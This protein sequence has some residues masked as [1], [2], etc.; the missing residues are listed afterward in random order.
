MDEYLREF[1]AQPDAKQKSQVQWQPKTFTEP[2]K[3][4]D[5]YPVGNDQPETHMLTVNWLLN[6]RP[7]TPLQDLTLDVLNHLLMGT[8][9]AKLRKSLMESGLGVAMTG[10]GVSD[11]LLQATFSVGLKGIQ[12]GKTGE[13][14]K[15]ILDTLESVAREGFAQ[16]EIAS[17]LNTIEFQMREFNTGS[18]PKGLSF[19]LGSMN[20]W[21]Y[22]NSPT[23]ALKFEE[24]LKQLKE[25]IA[26][27]GS[28]IFQDM[29]KTMLVDN[30]HRTTVELAPSKTLEQEILKD[31]ES[32]LAAIK[33][34]M[35]DEEL[36]DVVRKTIELKK[37]Q[38]RE[39]P[40][41]ARATIPQLELSDLKRETTEYPIVVTKNEG[42]SGV[43]VVRHEMG[44]TSGIAYCNLMVDLSRL[45]LDDV[46][47]LPLFTRVMKETGAGDMDS[48]ALS[49]KIG[50]HTG[51]IDVKLFTSPVYEEGVD[52]SNAGSG[53]YMVTKLQIQGKAT[54]EKID[55]LFDLFKV[56]LTDARFD[57][58]SKV[59][60]LLKE[61]KSR[62]ES[63]VQGSGH[64]IVNTRMKARHRVDGYVEEVTDGITH[65]SEVKKLLKTAEEDWPSLLTRLETIRSTILDEEY[66]RSGMVLDVTGDENVLS[67]I[68]PSL[69]KFLNA[70]PGKADGSSM[71]DAYSNPHPWAAE[72]KKKMAEILPIKDE[73]FVVPTQ[74]NY[75]GKSGLLYDVG[76]HIPG[77][78]AVV[79]RFLRTGYIW[80][81]VRVMGGAYGGYCM[82]SPYSGYLSFLS[83]RDPNLDKTID[84]YDA[85]ADALT[86]IADGLE[87]DPAALAKAIIGAIGDMDKALS[88]D[89]KGVKQ[90]Q[91]WLTNETAEYRQKYRDE[92]LSTK[93]SDFRD[94]AARLRNMKSASVAVVSSKAGFE[95]AAK[96]GKEMML[97]EI[98]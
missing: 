12:P 25:S 2:K 52:N 27:S 86:E 9:S 26:T 54:S 69:D 13:V 37:L 49:R 53:D 6:D 32:R 31:E 20:K 41:E 97:N 4:L 36:E 59:I 95:A 22:D 83:Y 44:S 85:T 91:R 3:E 82:F 68:K 75:V 72:A 47:L 33:S 45:P 35:S 74:V 98:Y 94:F 39:D 48:V 18:F 67:R 64:T 34:K 61:T 14:E 66:C 93:P 80:D 84:V 88:V 55:E 19:M 65:L 70:L 73:G 71:P 92:I 57:A 24:P 43:T 30:S 28:K 90:M 50:T 56:M 1:D 87:N 96:A 15:L 76:E 29:V 58:Q 11:V 60:E 63:R 78:A 16:D 77:S 5:Y 8:T 40:P 89:Q 62:L 81:R 46:P 21:I 17:S 23:D 51:G 38:S 79:S 42:G 10:R 7:L